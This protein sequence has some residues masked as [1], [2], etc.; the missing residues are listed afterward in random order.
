M[1]YSENQ[2]GNAIVVRIPRWLNWRLVGLIFSVGVLV[3][4]LPI[5]LDGR[6][7]SP[8]DVYERLK[9]LSRLS[10]VEYKLSTVV[11]V[12][13]PR[14]IRGDEVLVYGVCGRVVAGIDLSKLEK[15][16]VKTTGPNVHI[17]LPQAEMFTLDLILENDMRYVPPYEL[18][19]KDRTVEM[20]STCEE[21]YSW[22]VPFPLTRTPE[23]VT[24]AQEE[25]LKAFKETAERNKILV[26]AQNNAE[27]L[28]WDLLTKIGYE[29]VEVEF[30]AQQ[31]F[32]LP[33]ELP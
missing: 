31:E 9:D 12:V 3:F 25:A 16:D 32:E 21:T 20:R 2:Q 26:E 4:I 27:T 11:K 19:E 22:T 33:K 15:E 30:E 1:S 14:G 24:D 29:T 10:T 23:L 13:N 18:G 17:T 8:D 5:V 6:D 7:G 28:L